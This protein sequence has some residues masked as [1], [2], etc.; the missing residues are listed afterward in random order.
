MDSNSSY[1]T[2][3]STMSFIKLINKYIVNVPVIQRDYAQGRITDDVTE[4]RKQF[5]KDLL[6]YISDDSQSHNIDYVYGT[7][8]HSDPEKANIFI[9]LDGQQ[10]LTTLFL[11][12]LYIAGM[13]NHFEEFR[14]QIDGRFRYSTRKSSTEFCKGL[15]N[16][17]IWDELI[18]LRNDV[19]ETKLSNVIEN[20]G[21][22][23]QSWKQDPTVEGM[24]VMLNEIDR[25]I[26]KNRSLQEG[27][28]Y[29]D[30]IADYLNM[31]YNG[32]FNSKQDPIV[33]QWQPLDGYTRTDDLYIKMNARGLK[34]TDFEIFK[35]VYEKSLY[36]CPDLKQC[37]ETN[38]DGSWC[39][40]FWAHK[41][42]NTDIVLER[43]IRLMIG[44][45]YSTSVSNANQDI[46]DK[47]FC[48]NGKDILF[49][50]SKFY[51]L[52]IFHDIHTK[53]QDIPS[54]IKNLERKIAEQIIDAMQI[55]CELYS[56]DKQDISCLPWYDVKDQIDS[57]LNVNLNKIGY[58]QLVYF[59]AYIR[60]MAKYTGDRTTELPQWIRL[61]Y[62]LANATNIN[63][64][65][66]MA[67]VFVSIERM[68]ENLQ[69]NTI[70]D[71]LCTKPAISKFSQNQ[72]FEEYIKANLLKWGKDNNESR[73]E[74]LIKINEA[75][76]YMKGQ[77]GFLLVIS[78]VYKDEYNL[79][80]KEDS[81]K[82]LE[83]F[84]TASR[85]ARLIFSHFKRNTSDKLVDNHL[86]EQAMLISGMYLRHNSSSRLNFCNQP[87]DRDNSW[88]KL[89]E[90]PF[91]EKNNEGIKAFGQVIT[92]KWS[93]ENDAIESLEKIY[94]TYMQNPT[95]SS[96][97]YA[98][99]LG[100]YGKKLINICSQGFI[101]KNNEHITLLHQSQMNHYH[102]ELLSRELHLELKT[103]YDF[104]HYARVRSGEEKPGIYFEIP[105]CDIPVTV[106]IYND[107]GWLLEIHD[108]SMFNKLS[109]TPSWE[110]CAEDLSKLLGKTREEI[111]D[112]IKIDKAY[113][114]SLLSSVKSI[115]SRNSEPS[116]TED[117]V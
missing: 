90:V 99:F 19:P 91:K 88:R 61:I 26:N 85:H 37:F 48:F 43:I 45:G 112:Y 66:D 84:D 116:H 93:N 63:K 114:M 79:F 68:L 11:L 46:L 28:S 67:D 6:F 36:H 5:V 32:L 17:S 89:L 95:H 16:S 23:F 72:V 51:D 73:W 71:W 117:N 115:I 22:F 18:S 15:L 81:D 98:P 78:G 96:V 108:K 38:I 7:V 58:E 25:Q 109:A 111:K 92:A 83:T 8:E 33:F 64:S 110:T 101:H 57:V 29:E 31:N 3:A 12:H 76:D 27:I 105:I 14:I 103:V 75:D 53:E 20:Q 62:N 65:T 24:L 10:R 74:D 113:I 55:L 54:D 42:S 50:Y 41:N 87:F 13:S 100:S 80:C 104:I 77:I 86:L 44:C 97:W 70:I 47:I 94:D 30:S 102:S 4:I 39:D 52:N 9:P 21:W 1:M 35:A 106:F 40:S 59:Y 82:A 49:A 60:F 56:P 69:S 107:K 34:L 2:P